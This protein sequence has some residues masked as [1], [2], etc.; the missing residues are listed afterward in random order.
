MKPLKEQYSDKL[1][2]ILELSK[3]KNNNIRWNQNELAFV[4]KTSKQNVSRWIKQVHCPDPLAMERIDELL[5][6]LTSLEKKINLKNK[7]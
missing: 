7:G 6:K 2:K 5:E 4:L 3:Y 1:K